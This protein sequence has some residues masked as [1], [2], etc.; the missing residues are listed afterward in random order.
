MIMANR[1]DTIQYIRGKKHGLTMEKE[2]RGKQSRNEDKMGEKQPGSDSDS[3]GL[4]VGMATD[5]SE[6]R[7]PTQE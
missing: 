4:R 2:A 7:G 6:L 5:W 3:E 1:H